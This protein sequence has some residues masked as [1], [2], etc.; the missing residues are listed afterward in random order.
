MCAAEG[1]GC[2]EDQV[3]AVR[4]HGGIIKLPQL[5]A[6]MAILGRPG[7]A[8][9]EKESRGFSSTALVGALFGP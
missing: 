8:I 3:R 9:A 7:I 1:H 6:G 5:P 2:R 4:I